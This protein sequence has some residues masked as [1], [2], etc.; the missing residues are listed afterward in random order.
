MAFVVSVEV[1]QQMICPFSLGMRIP[2]M[3]TNIASIS[4]GSAPPQQEQ[5]FTCKVGRCMAWLG[6][7]KDGLGCCSLIASHM[8]VIAEQ[9]RGNVTPDTSIVAP[10]GEN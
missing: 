1:A 6:S 5:I 8:N 2:V 4:P 10:E 9:E 7:S 3:V